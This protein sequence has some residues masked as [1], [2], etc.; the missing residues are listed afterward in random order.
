VDAGLDGTFGDDARLDDPPLAV[1]V[2]QEGVQGAHALGDPALDTRPFAGL[3][4]PWDGVDVEVGVAVGAAE[5]RAARAQVMGHALHEIFQVAGF[6][7]L[8]QGPVMRPRRA[9]VVVGLVPSSVNRCVGAATGVRDCLHPC[10]GWG[11]PRGP[12]PERQKLVVVGLLLLER[13]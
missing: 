6:Q 1:D 4:E 13:T 12:Y 8:D 7:D 3:D 9:V 5:A 2:G 10:S 11:V